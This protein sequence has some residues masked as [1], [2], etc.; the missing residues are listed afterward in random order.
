MMQSFSHQSFIMLLR[1]F[2]INN[3]IH[4]HAPYFRQKTEQGHWMR[5]TIQYWLCVN[6]TTGDKPGK[7]VKQPRES[8]EDDQAEKTRHAWTQ[9]H[10]HTLIIEGTSSSQ[11]CDTKSLE[12][13]QSMGMCMRGRR[14]RGG[15][16]SHSGSQIRHAGLGRPCGVDEGLLV[17]RGMTM[18]GGAVQDVWTGSVTEPQT[19]SSHSLGSVVWCVCAWHGVCVGSQV[20]ERLGNRASNQKVAGSIPGRVKWRCVLGQGTPPYW[21]LYFL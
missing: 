8:C 6:Y 11:G 12:G 14:C 1:S 21:P 2:T 20:A 15:V 13:D 5:F 7:D 17:Q 10:T 3:D 16:V 9:S 18:K 19:T 4:T